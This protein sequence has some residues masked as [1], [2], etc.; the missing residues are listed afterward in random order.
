MDDALYQ[1]VAVEPGE[2]RP[3]GAERGDAVD[4]GPHGDGVVVG[5]GGCRP[6]GLFAGGNGVD[7]RLEGGGPPVADGTLF[8]LV[9]LATEKKRV[10][11]GKVCAVPG[12]GEAGGLQAL[13]RVGNIA[14]GLEY[15]FGKV[16]VAA[17]CS[18]ATTENSPWSM[19]GTRVTRPRF[20]TR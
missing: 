20:L 9:A 10:P 3:A 2:G 19:P 13:D 12:V 6:A 16:L 11:L 17:C 18:K 7:Q 14:L 4:G 5:V 1:L 8:V 15:P